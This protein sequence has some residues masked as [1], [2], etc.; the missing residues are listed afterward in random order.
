M[1]LLTA[2]A[3]CDKD[4]NLVIKLLNWIKSLNSTLGIHKTGLLLAADSEMNRDDV[5]TIKNLGKEV[6]KNT[7]AIYIQVPKGAATWPSASNIMFSEVARHINGC[8]K[9]PWLWLEPDAVPLKP[10]WL[11]DMGMAYEYQPRRYMGCISENQQVKDANGK[12]EKVIKRQM[13]GVAVYPQNAYMELARFC[14]GSIPFDLQMAEHVCARAS[15]TY[16]I[17]NHW[18]DF[19]KPPTFSNEPL[20]NAVGLDF[21][22]PQAVIFHR[23]KDG[24]LIDLLSRKCD[25]AS[26]SMPKEVE[27]TQPEQPAVAPKR[28]GRPA[29]SLS[30]T[31][32]NLAPQANNK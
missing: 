29:K 20:P 27:Q 24:S 10:N 7:Q 23:C 21:I 15:H 32:N 26:E 14:A 17:Q 30:E 2:I 4:K 11:F 22:E 1:N 3:F 19:N 9:E 6:F 8:Y 31:V 28:R 12:L 13:S 16:L 18:G 25:S 5:Q